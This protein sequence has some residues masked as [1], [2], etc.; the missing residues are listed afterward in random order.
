MIA[1]NLETTAIYFK[2][3]TAMNKFKKSSDPEIEMST[4]PGP[5][6]SFP[7]YFLKRYTFAPEVTNCWKNCLQT[8]LM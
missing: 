6:N 3:S 5:L 4:D 7:V 1:G 8:S 2:M